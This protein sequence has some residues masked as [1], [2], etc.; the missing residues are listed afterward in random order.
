MTEQSE[1]I[2]GL[3]KLAIPALYI[4]WEMF[5][6]LQAGKGWGCVHGSAWS[7]VAVL[8]QHC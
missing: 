5:M 1:S 6:D 3:S 8:L 4:P 2:V 7:V